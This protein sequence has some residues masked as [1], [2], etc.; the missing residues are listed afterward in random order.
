MKL[1]INLIMALVLM[2]TPLAAQAKGLIRDAELELALKNL[3]APVIRAAGL[4]TSRIRILVINDTKLN[5]FV[6]DSRHVFIHSGLIRKLKR[7]FFHLSN[8][9]ENGLLFECAYIVFSL[10]VLLFLCY[11][12]N[13]LICICIHRI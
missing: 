7:T 12:H 5:A 9:L 1:L 3:A 13:F 2:L 6:V 10:L 11:Y 8:T 4:S